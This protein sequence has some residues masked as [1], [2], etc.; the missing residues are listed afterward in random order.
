MR[1]VI[2]ID[3]D[4]CNCLYLT[5]TSFDTL[6]SSIGPARMAIMLLI[7]RN[8]Q[9]QEWHVKWISPAGD[10]M[11]QLSAIPACTFH[12]PPFVLKSPIN[13]SAIWRW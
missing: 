2:D 1:T 8:K 7:Y 11:M 12:V 6:T 5:M 4:V 9:Y 10:L 3:D 13:V